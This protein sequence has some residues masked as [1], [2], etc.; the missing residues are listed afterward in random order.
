MKTCSQCNG[1]GQVTQRI[2]LAPGFVQQSQGPCPKCGGKGK[3]I[4]EKCPTCR[5]KRVERGNSQLTLVVE[6]GAPEGHEVRFEMEADQ[7]PDNIPGDVILSIIG[8]PDDVFTRKGNDLF[9]R[10]EITLKE[11]LLGFSKTFTHMDN[12]QVPIEANGITQHGTIRKIANE[13]MPVLGGG[14]GDLYVT[15]EFIS[16]KSLTEEQEKVI[17]ELF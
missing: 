13:G 12:R 15:I 6:R 2:Q 8:K 1:A 11:A 14:K 9:M 5:G 17:E 3:E 16:P 4:K 10:L 7:N